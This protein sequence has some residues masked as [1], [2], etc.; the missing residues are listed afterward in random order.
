M[1]TQVENNRSDLYRLTTAI[2]GDTLIGRDIQA[3]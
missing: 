1:I 3:D 2:E